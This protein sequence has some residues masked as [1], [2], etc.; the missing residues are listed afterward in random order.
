MLQIWTE[1]VGE[2][3]YLFDALKRFLFSIL[4]AGRRS[5]AR[6]NN[7]KHRGRLDF[8][9]ISK[10]RWH[11]N[12]TTFRFSTC[13]FTTINK[14]NT[15]DALA[16]VSNAI[17]FLRQIGSANTESFGAGR[18]GARSEPISS[19]VLRDKVR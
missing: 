1:S 7:S 4:F 19:T 9:R 6:D 14:L 3:L 2:E 13:K 8:T 11:I 16:I 15:I 12:N 10:N 5:S 17:L 18:R